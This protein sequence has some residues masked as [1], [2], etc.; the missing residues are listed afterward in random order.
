MER[1]TAA[2]QQRA[3]QFLSRDAEGDRLQASP[4]GAREDAAH[5]IGSNDLGHRDPLRG[6]DKAWFR[7]AGSERRQ[8]IQNGDQV[9]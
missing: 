2:A 9:G 3:A 1:S 5:M 7:I 8:S 6:E 4:V